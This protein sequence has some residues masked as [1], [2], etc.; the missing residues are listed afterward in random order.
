MRKQIQKILLASS[1]S[2]IAYSANAQE[3]KE[4]GSVQDVSVWRS[5][6]ISEDVSGW[7]S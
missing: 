3:K 4:A 7:L 6:P 1:V 2:L 5:I